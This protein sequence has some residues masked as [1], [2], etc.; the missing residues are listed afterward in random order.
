[1]VLASGGAL[2]GPLGALLGRLG[3][4]LGHLGPSWG[5][6]GA[7]LGRLEAIRSRLDALLDVRRPKM[8]KLLIFHMFLQG[9]GTL[10]PRV[11]ALSHSNYE[12]L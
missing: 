2:G 4:L 9:F 10:D 3:G 11:R 5:H 1:M 6:I 12:G 8:P 7:V